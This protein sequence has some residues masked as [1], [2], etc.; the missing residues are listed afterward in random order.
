MTLH[1][2]L[3]RHGKSYWDNPL[4]TDHQ[5]PLAPRGQRAAPLIG[6]WLVSHGHVP[7]EALVSDAQR[8]RDT[9]ALLSARLPAPVPARFEPALYLAGPDIMLRALHSATQDSVLMLGHNPGIAEFAHL[10][11]ITPPEDAGFKRYPTCATLV[12][13]FDVP[14]WSD[15]T[16][17]TGRFVDF[18]QPRT[19]EATPPQP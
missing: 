2:I 16:Y 6:D 10:L 13:A 7:D 5:R 11:L 12:A 14:K 3:T 19:L 8:T 9:W 18:I 15:V 4:D 17:G 1:L